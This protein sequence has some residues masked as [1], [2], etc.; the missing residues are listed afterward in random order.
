LKQRH[1]AKRIFERLRD[2]HG[3]AGGLTAVRDHVR[4]ARGRLRETFILLA[5]PPGHAQVDVSEAV[6]VTVSVRPLWKR[7][8]FDL[9]PARRRV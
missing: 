5:H 6:G 8:A 1:T 3:Y 2:E 9:T 7:P 4:I